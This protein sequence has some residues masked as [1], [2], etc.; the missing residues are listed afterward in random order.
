MTVTAKLGFTL[1]ELFIVM[2][3]ISVVAVIAIPSYRY[4]LERSQE[5]I[6]KV[7]LLRLITFAQ[8]AAIAKHAQVY[9]CKS[10]DLLHCDGSWQDGELVA[11]NANNNNGEMNEHDVLY[12]KEA[13]AI[14]RWQ[15][16]PRYRDHILFMSTGLLASDNATFWYCRDKNTTPAFAVFL[17][18]TGRTR[19]LYPD[20]QGRIFDSK[21]RLLSCS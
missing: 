3:I 6:A 19:V 4:L 15:S 12:E 17:S 20:N 8:Q 5:D 7:E 18:K 11:L 14:L 10:K 9:I 16:Y 13:R 2:A 1:I 21:K